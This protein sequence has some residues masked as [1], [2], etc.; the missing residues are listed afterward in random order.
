MRPLARAGLVLALAG[1][2]VLGV[3]ALKSER[4]VTKVAIPVK[5]GGLEARYFYLHER[6]VR[7]LVEVIPSAASVDVEVLDLTQYLRLTRGE[8]HGHV[9]AIRGT[10][11][12]DFRL[13]P[14]RGVYFFVFRNRTNAGIL[15]R[16]TIAA[17]GLER[18]CLKVG[19]ALLVLGLA[20]AAVSRV[21]RE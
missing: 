4:T 10:N 7:V 19:V 9:Y 15:V 16:L 20:L 8:P 2:A 11:G 5:A 17:E 18:G 12:A 21:M 1:L 13:H 6:E 14:S 3:V